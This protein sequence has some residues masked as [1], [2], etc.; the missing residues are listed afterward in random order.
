MTA[1]KVH[2]TATND[3][4]SWD[5][6]AEEAKLE[7]PIT[8]SVGQGM[9][10]WVDM[11]GNDGD[12][13]GWLDA[14]TDHK[15]PHHF[16]TDGKPGEASIKGVNNALSRLPNAKIPESD[17]PGV[18]KHMNAH[19]TDAG[20]TDWTE[21]EAHSHY[22]AIRVVEGSAQ[23]H[24]P[25]WAAR[26]AAKAGDPGEIDFFGYISEISWLNDEITP[27]KFKE[28]LARVGQ[29]GPIVIRL[30][31]GG[32]EI[33]AAAAI[34]AML[35]D[36]P[37]RIMVKILGLAASAAVAIALAGDEIQ[38]FDTAY[39]MIHNPGYT[40]IMG[41]LT[42]DVLRQFADELDL[43]RE[44]IMGAY[45]ARTGMDRAAI[46]EMMDAETW[47]TAQ[48]AVD[49]G[50][51]DK[52][53]SGET[54]PAKIN[55]GT[56]RNYAHVPAGLVNAVNSGQAPD[57]SQTPQANMPGPMQAHRQQ[58]GA[59]S[60]KYGGKTMDYLRTL[61]AQRQEM[62]DLVQ[63][64]MDTAEKEGRDFNE[65]ERADYDRIMGTDE[66]PGELPQLDADI[67]RMIIEREKVRA[68]AE[69]KFTVPALNSEKVERPETSAPASM[70]RAEFDKLPSDQKAAF[71]QRGGKVED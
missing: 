71:I 52:V 35:M 23:P 50:F 46:T 8:K 13:D 34:R 60:Q 53:V 26:P 42:A 38:I 31:S 4:R 40:G 11:T 3:T 30:H 43:F 32:G 37:G 22:Q 47:M 68:A 59:V 61:L 24:Q 57:E 7:T 10:G 16:V 70:K 36:Y 25:F 63:G 56:L 6:P 55:P 44:G 2:H 67:D 28:D 21:E 39:M 5:G 65:E 54:A 62:L 58:V 12:G 29:G 48:Q 64:H 27:A 15:F 18:K 45:T 19:R 17:K 9:Y 49:L 20:L 33:F 1:I 69:R 51:A 14:K 41:W 66:N